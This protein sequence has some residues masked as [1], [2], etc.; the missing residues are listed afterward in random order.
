MPHKP[1]PYR[2]EIGAKVRFRPEI[3]NHFSNNVELQLTYVVVGRERTG[4]GNHVEELYQLDGLG[5]RYGFA[6]VA[7]ED[8][9]EKVANRETM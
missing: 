6:L 1:K 7:A 8:E 5:T 3:R 4:R 9:D 2:F